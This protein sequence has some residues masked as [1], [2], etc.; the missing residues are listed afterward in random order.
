MSKI[1]LTKSFQRDDYAILEIETKA[2]K[3]ILNVLPDYDLQHPDRVWEYAMALRALSEMGDVKKVLDVGSGASPFPYILH[4]LGYDVD[5]TDV[6]ARPGHHGHWDWKPEWYIWESTFFYENEYDAVTSISVVEH[7]ER[8]WPAMSAWLRLA[9][10][11]IFVT[12]DC[13]HDGRRVVEHHIRSFTLDHMVDYARSV[14]AR[15]LGGVDTE[16][17]GGKECVF[18]SLC[19]KAK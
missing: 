11:G 8:P 14:S 12:Y 1:Q 5:C 9:K 7:I 18:A 13:T 19:I 3:D 15:F 2:I 10:N 4:K 16:F 6:Q 17:H